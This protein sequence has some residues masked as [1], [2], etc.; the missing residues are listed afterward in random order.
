MSNYTIRLSRPGLNGPARIYR[1]QLDGFDAGKLGARS[2]IDIPANGGVHT[3]AFCWGGKTERIINVTLN[4]ENPLAEINVTLDMTGKLNLS[5]VSGVTAALPQQDLSRGFKPKK[6]MGCLSAA[7]VIL[8]VFIVIVIVGTMA[9]G[10]NS[11]KSSPNVSERPSSA[12]PVPAS[13]AVPEFTPVTG[14]AGNWEI[15][16]NDFSFQDDVSVG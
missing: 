13:T 5:L 14:Y 1:I 3:I 16:V 11:A 9:S 7:G 15:T 6:K 12:A 2:T 10:S 4:E 8:S